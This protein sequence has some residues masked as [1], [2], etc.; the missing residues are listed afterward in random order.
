MTGS[1]FREGETAGADQSRA[2]HRRRPGREALDAHAALSRK[3]LGRGSA[4][5][6][7]RTHSMRYFQLLE[8]ALSQGQTHKPYIWQLIPW[9]IT[10]MH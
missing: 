6:H 5:V 1:R 9:Y 4:H 2:G 7:T 8:H 10:Y 3:G